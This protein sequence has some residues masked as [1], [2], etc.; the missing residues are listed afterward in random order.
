MTIG[1]SFRKAYEVVSKNWP[2]VLIN[3]ATTVVLLVFFALLFML[4]VALKTGTGGLHFN[5]NDPYQ[6]R[7]FFSGGHLQTVLTGCLVMLLW[8]LVASVV[9]IYVYAGAVGVMKETL[10]G[11]HW[12]FSLRGFFH[13]ANSLFWP[14]TGYFGLLFLVV[15]GIVL[16][17][18]IFFVVIGLAGSVMG[19][20]PEGGMAVLVSV[21]GVFLIIG[22]IL[23]FFALVFI[24][25]SLS[26]YGTA[27][28]AFRDTGVM[29]GLKKAIKFLWANPR[30]FWG[31]VFSVGIL[32]LI[33]MIL[34]LIG[35]VL[36]I[37]PTAGK[38]LV[39]P[40]NIF[41]WS[42]QI[43]VAY[44][45]TAVAMAFYSASRQVQSQEGPLW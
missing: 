39:W 28:I 26:A 18:V 34:A 15:I 33:S 17:I 45:S 7:E 41:T 19:S 29:G 11:E 1:E 10:L 31:Y 43:Y 27:I 4:P 44:W 37:I 35:L 3:M 38:V 8:I 20:V 14:I 5:F 23:G 2:L 13:Q 24:F 6:M 25:A 30:A 12:S 40:Y 16:A 32:W 9:G 21:M 36:E 42:V 22:A